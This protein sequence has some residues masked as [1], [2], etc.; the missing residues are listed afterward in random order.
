MI[1]N[2]RVRHVMIDLET[3]AVDPHAAVMQV[4]IVTNLTEHLVSVKPSYYQPPTN[5][6]YPYKVSPETIAFHEKS[7]PENLKYCEDY[8]G[9]PGAAAIQVS[10]Y[11]ERLKCGGKYSLRIWANGTDFDIPI[12]TNLLRQEGAKIPWGYTYVRDY[13]T[14]REMFKQVLPVKYKNDHNA[15]N[16]ARNQYFHLCEMLSRMDGSRSAGL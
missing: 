6:Y 5:D 16:D 8:G 13:R 12:L 3:L 14:L 7:A 2:D 15:V 9:S 4:G 11:L 1:I 10:D